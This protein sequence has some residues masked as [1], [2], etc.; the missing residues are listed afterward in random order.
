[1]AVVEPGPVGPPDPDEAPP[2]VLVA[3]EAAAP[4]V[5]GEGFA[6]LPVLPVEPDGALGE[7][8]VVVVVVAVEVVPVVV[9]PGADPADPAPGT[10]S[11]G[12]PVVFA[13]AVPPPPQ[14]LRPQASVTASTKARTMRPRTVTGV[15]RLTGVAEGSTS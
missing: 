13:V 2:V 14:A 10:V 3:P 5:L 1:M 8:E 6:E 11:V 12:A 7:V 15:A 4:P 9:A